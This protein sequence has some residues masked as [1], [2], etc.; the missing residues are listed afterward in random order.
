MLKTCFIYSYRNDSTGFLV[1][2]RQ[3][4]QH[5][6]NRAMMKATATQITNTLFSNTI[7]R[8]MLAPFTFLIPISFLRLVIEKADNPDNPR[9]AMMMPSRELVRNTMRKSTSSASRAPTQRSHLLENPAT[10]GMPAMPSAPIVK[11]P[12]VKG[13]FL[14]MPS[15]WL[16]FVL[17]VCA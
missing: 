11:A 13:I 16:I 17:C 14:P 5:T 6:V 2:A 1:D 12:I 10:G 8:E 9:Q 15:S 3:L 7:T 4:C